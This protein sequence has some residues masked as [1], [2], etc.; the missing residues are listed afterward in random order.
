M[1]LNGDYFYVTGNY[2]F[3][4]EK[5]QSNTLVF[6]FP[7]DSLMGEVD[8]IYLYNLTTNETIELLRKEKNRI[9]FKTYF[10]D[11]T[12]LEILISY[13][14]KLLGNHA[15]YILES[16]IN[17]GKPLDQADYQL[18]IPRSWRLGN[19]SIPP[20]DSMMTDTEVIYYWSKT[21]FLPMANL[22]FEFIE[23]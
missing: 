4:S 6:P 20:D 13:R 14:Q 8:S 16:T 17:W 22:D 3:K 15:E 2:Y 7:A 23:N 12:E 1:K 19:C 5:D 21:D 11:H 9:V 18:I 10:G